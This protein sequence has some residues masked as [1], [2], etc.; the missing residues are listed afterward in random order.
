MSSTAQDILSQAYSLRNRVRNIN[1][2]IQQMEEERDQVE[3]EIN[4]LMGEWRQ[5][6]RQNNI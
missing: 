4:R 5:I 3:H 1:F 2:S 6:N